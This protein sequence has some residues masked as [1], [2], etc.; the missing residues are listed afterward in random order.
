MFGLESVHE[1]AAV[2]HPQAAVVHEQAALRF[3]DG[4]LV[5]LARR[6]R[7]RARRER[8]DALGERELARALVTTG[9][10][11]RRRGVRASAAQI[12]GFCERPALTG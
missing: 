10:C 12:D 3:D 5:E 2:S 11:A 7:E 1:R 4:G 9:L 8:D 6:E